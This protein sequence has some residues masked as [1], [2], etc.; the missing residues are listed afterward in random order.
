MRWLVVV[1]VV[2]FFVNPIAGMQLQKASAVKPE[3]DKLGQRYT[4][5]GRFS[6]SILVAQN[7]AVIYHEHF[8]LAD[9]KK[10]CPFPG[11]QLL[12]QGN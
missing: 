9:L 7:D 8:G 4:E 6:G 10:K 3:I 11:R 12:K 1:L 5:L 2:L